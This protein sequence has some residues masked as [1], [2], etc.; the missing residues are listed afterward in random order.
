MALRFGSIRLS[1]RVLNRT[2]TLRVCS[3]CRRAKRCRKRADMSLEAW[4]V[5]RY[6]RIETECIRDLQ[7][8]HATRSLGQ[9]PARSLCIGTP[10]GPHD[11]HDEAD[12][13]SW[14]FIR[15]PTHFPRQGC[16]KMLD[17][18]IR[19]SKLKERTCF[20]SV[21]TWRCDNLARFARRRARVIRVWE[22]Y[23]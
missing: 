1:G 19:N 12:R 22:V 10:K 5:Q 8:C 17:V 18:G 9:V 21:L 4:G 6:A 2:G 3:T 23:K 11:H 16:P 15:L 20:F 7:T 13:G 14:C